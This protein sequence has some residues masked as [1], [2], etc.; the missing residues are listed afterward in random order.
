MNKKK[1]CHQE[2]SNAYHGI[3]INI[4]QKDKSIFDKLKIVGKKMLIF[5]LIIL[6]KVKVNE[7]EITEVVKNVQNNMAHKSWFLFKNF[8]AHFYRENELI[9]VFKKKAFFVSPDKNTWAEAIEYGKRL[10]INDKQLDFIPNR[11]EDEDY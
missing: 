7:N 8:Y 5:G 6:Y 3:I 9:I 4:S 2:N 11:F 1:I 10:N